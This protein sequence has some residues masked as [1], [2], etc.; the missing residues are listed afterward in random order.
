MEYLSVD[1]QEYTLDN[2]ALNLQS[3]LLF[4]QFIM[5]VYNKQFQKTEYLSVISNFRWLIITCI[6][7]GTTFLAQAPKVGQRFR[8]A[9]NVLLTRV[10]NVP[11][12]IGPI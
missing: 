4:K 5:P 8:A 7:I 11:E 10:Q 2:H 3:H 6:I 1:H 12:Y 9:T